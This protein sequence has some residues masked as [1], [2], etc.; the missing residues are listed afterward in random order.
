MGIDPNNH[1]LNHSLPR[2][3][4][5]ILTSIETIQ[6][7]NDMNNTQRYDNDQVSDARSCLD[8]ETPRGSLTLPD[9]N[10]DLSMSF[11][12]PSSSLGINRDEDLEKKNQ[13]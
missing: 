6:I 9:L 8:D 5:P 7:K 3:A 11:P 12:S 10:L 2:P 13:H 4:H 1:R